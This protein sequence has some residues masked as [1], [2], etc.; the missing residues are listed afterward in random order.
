V[1][2][3]RE[4]PAFFTAR[5][6]DESNVPHT[7]HLRTP[8]LTIYEVL[9]RSVGGEGVDGRAVQKALGLR[10]LY[11]AERLLAALSGAQ[12][13][14]RTPHEFI[15]AAQELMAAP[16]QEKLEFLFRLHDADGDG[17]IRPR[18][19]ER[20]FHLSAAEHE[21]MLADAE[22]DQL[23]QAVMEAGDGDRDGRIDLHEFVT[24]IGS[25]P[26]MYRRLSDYGVSLLMPGA[27]ARRK[28]QM[29]GA[30]FRGWVRNEVVLAL[31]IIAYGLACTF[32]FTQAVLSQRAL[33]AHVYI[34]IARGFGACLNFNAAL[35]VVPMLRRTLTRVRLSVLGRVVPVDDAV[36]L[37]GRLG[38]LT[39]V[40]GVAHSGAHILNILRASIDPWLHSYVS[41]YILLASMLVIWV[42][43]REVVRRSKRFELFYVSHLTYF[44]MVP[45]L[46]IHSKHFWMWGALPWCWFLFERSLRSR[47]RRKRTHVLGAKLYNCGVT[48]LDLARPSNF[49]YKPGDYVFLRLPE[50]ARHE[51][52][53]FTLT[54]A[55]EQPD[56]LTV[57]IRTVGD[58]TRT[59][60]ERVP[61]L[62]RR[63][64]ATHVQI[65][66]PYGTASR[67]IL[68]VR[69]AVAIAGGIGVTPFAPIMK[70]LLMRQSD[71]DGSRPRLEK[72]R[73]VW[74]NR[75]QRAFEWFRDLLERL[76]RADTRRLLE[77]HTFMTSGRSELAGGMLDFA[78]YVLHSRARGDLI[79]GLRSQTSLGYPD[80]DRLLE[81][82]YRNPTLPPPE[83]F[84]CG[85]A[86]LERVVTKSCRRLGLRLRCERF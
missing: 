57:H 49:T 26:E 8:L 76:E 29:P 47:R 16:P 74:L 61:P 25:Q 28:N 23:V 52:H 11:L 81:A 1:R 82:F 53:P 21:L 42:G 54:S 9:R 35:L 40:F 85:P 10:S 27:R 38:E 3:A 86:R 44:L 22:F 65:D 70:S 67:H 75:D 62:L 73:F 77:I 60:R 18:E 4:E 6:L 69:H 56:L 71:D 80:F 19:L 50:V 17:W 43:S 7:T 55:P 36:M 64:D 15:A 79:T 66:G 68:D 48:R 39:C 78:R 14:F 83:V 37:H 30:N 2:A 24:M 59:V 63:E 41:G 51:W 58:W 84:F 34:Q 12:R 13:R 32:L 33:G 5:A 20:M 31:W 46:F 45:V 72:L